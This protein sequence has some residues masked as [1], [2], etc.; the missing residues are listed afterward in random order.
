MRLVDCAFTTRSRPRSQTRKRGDV[1]TTDDL[2]RIAARRASPRPAARELLTAP[3]PD[4]PAISPA[5]GIDRIVAATHRHPYLLQRVGDE[6]ERLLNARG[7]LH[8]AT[9]AEVTDVP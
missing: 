3:A 7:G 9:D 8:A 5:G 4:F 1:A 6:L 2:T